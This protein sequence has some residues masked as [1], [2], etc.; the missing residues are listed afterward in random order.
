MKWFGCL[1]IASVFVFFGYVNSEAQA[2][3][4]AR[5]GVYLSREN[6]CVSGL[7]AVHP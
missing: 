7:P 4:E 5:G 1:V 6:A 3:C 2:K